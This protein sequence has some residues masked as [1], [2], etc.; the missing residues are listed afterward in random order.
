MIRSFWLRLI[1]RKALRVSDRRRHLVGNRCGSRAL[2]EGA[3]NI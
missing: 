2:G 1:V 3:P